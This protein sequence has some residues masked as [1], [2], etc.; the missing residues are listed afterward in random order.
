MGVF[1]IDQWRQI[2][3]TV[4][5]DQQPVANQSARMAAGD[6]DLSMDFSAPTTD[7]LTDVLAKWVPGGDGNFSGLKDEELTALFR[8]QDQTLDEAERLKLARQFLDRFVQLQYAITTFGT[9]R[10][11]VFDKKVNGWKNPPSYAVG[12]DLKKMWLQK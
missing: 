7:D 1:L 10:E 9:Y 2:G 4:T 3:V 8:K 6:F 12:L 5:L 11:V